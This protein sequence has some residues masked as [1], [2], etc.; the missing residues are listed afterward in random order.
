MAVLLIK[1]A[2]NSRSNSD[3]VNANNSTEEVKPTIF[4]DFLGKGGASDS[5][6]VEGKSAAGD[7]RPQFDASPS[8]S[9]SAGASSGCGLGPI[10]TTSDLGSERHVQNHFGG[11]PFNV[12][13]SDFSGAEISNRLAG[14]K[15]SNSDSA[16]MGSSRD[17]FRQMQ[18]DSLESSH[19]MKILRNA[20][21]ERA[22]RSRDE[23]AYF[24]MRPRR[25]T[26]SSLMLQPATSGRIDANSCKWERTM[27]V[28]VGPTVQYPP[29]GGQVVPFGYQTPSNLLKDSDVG[30]S[31]ISQAAADE[32]SRTGIKGSGILSSVSA[33]GGISDRNPSGVLPGGGKQKTETRIV[34][35]ESS[36]PPS[37]QRL[38]SASCQMT[39]FYGGQAHVFDDVHPNK[40]DVI[41]ALAGSTGGSW[42]TNYAPKSAVRSSPVENYRLGGEIDIRT[43]SNF[44]L[45]PELRGK[46][47][48]AGNSS[49]GFDSGDRVQPGVH[50]GVVVRRDAR[51]P[52]QAVELCTEQK[53]EV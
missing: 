49:R 45:S 38:A 43:G 7:A 47:S 12:P 52:V 40:A 42:S 26:L 39:I 24:D 25:P 16:F 35:P 9:V 50:Q 4:H 28:N 21:G 10:S 2:H 30:P 29:R 18:P 17:G 32:G 3:H 37:G 1:M 41:M 8:A 53:R 22:R 11:M 48:V 36:T 34:E 13:R 27:P 33:S 31:V 14:R 5:S 6:P 23:E 51:A 15:R 20:G 44:A 46:L 19:L